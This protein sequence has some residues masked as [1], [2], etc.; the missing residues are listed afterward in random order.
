MDDLDS[1]TVAELKQLLKEKGL[2]VS[3][4]KAELIARLEPEEDFIH[5]YDEDEDEEDDI[6][7]LKKPSGDKVEMGCPSCDARIR[8]P[9][10]YSGKVKCP[11]CD[12]SFDASEIE[13]PSTP[14]RSPL[15]RLRGGLAEGENFRWSH[16]WLGFFSPSFMLWLLYA[17]IPRMQPDLGLSLASIFGI[18]LSIHGHATGNRA[19]KFGTLTG[20]V[21]VPLIFIIGCFT[22]FALFFEYK[23]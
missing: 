2:P 17:L 4:K 22:F 18:G 15:M 3:G 11:A 19:L 12:H 21:V 8:V 1:L 9:S 5:L 10:D 20:L 14:F 6:P 7:E 23:N 13:T 16:Y